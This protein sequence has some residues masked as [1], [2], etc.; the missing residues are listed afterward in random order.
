[1][2]KPSRTSVSSY[3]QINSLALV[4]ANY[5]KNASRLSMIIRVNIVLN[6]SVIV[7]ND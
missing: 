7:H 5:T 3:H 1:M 6:K 4:F 2:I